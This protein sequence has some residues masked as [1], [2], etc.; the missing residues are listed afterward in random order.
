MENIGRRNFVK[1]A[2]IL[3]GVAACG[4]LNAGAALAAPAQVELP[5]LPWGYQELDPEELRKLG[6]LGYYAYEC[7]G[8]VF[9]ALVTALKEKIGYPYTAIATPTKEDVIHYLKNKKKKGGPHLPPMF[10]QYGVGG[11]ANYGTL[12]G[13]PNGASSLINIAVPMDPAKKEIIPRLLRYYETEAFPTD[14]SNKYAMNNEFYP[15]K[16][17]S[18]KALP[19]VVGDSVLCHISVGTWCEKSGYASGSKERSERCARITGDVA[20]MTAK[21]L[22]ATIQDNLAT[23][24]PLGLSQETAECRTCHSKGE[25]YETGQFTRGSMECGSCHDETTI[26]KG[27]NK[28]KTAYGVEVGTWAGAAVVGTVAGIGSHAVASRKNKEEGNDEE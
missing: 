7:S 14:A 21:L 13:A 8:G 2:A 26:H 6:H 5:P 28:L 9:W 27:E 17:K 23:V 12:C 15:P 18:G 16:Y 25:E 3:S 19:Q 22:N 24:F 4:A 20:A 1:G 11:V 10:M